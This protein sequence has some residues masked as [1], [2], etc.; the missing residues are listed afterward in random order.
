MQCRLPSTRKNGARPLRFVL[1]K[2]MNTDLPGQQIHVIACGVLAA[3]ISHLTKHL[4]IPCSMEFLPG[5][6]HAR[7]KE[8]RNQLQQRI[9][10]ASAEFRGE[11]IV[12]GY[13]VCGLGTVGLHA[14]NVPLAI[15][16]VNDC[17]ALFLGSNAAYREQFGRYPG[18]YYVSAGWVDENAHPQTSSEHPIQC[19]P[20]CFT[21]QQL[22][23][24]YGEDN[25][26][27]IRDFLNSWQRNYQRAAYI[28]TGVTNRRGYAELARAMAE[29][30]GWKYE[31]LAGTHNLLTELITARHSTERVLCV[32]PHHVTAHDPVNHFLQAV[33]IWKTESATS[34]RDSTL[35]FEPP[36]GHE[37]RHGPQVKRGLGI[38]AG[39]TYTD[40]VLYDFQTD[41]VMAK[42]KSLTTKWDFTRGIGKALD[43]LG[44][45]RPQDVELVSISTTLATNAIVENRGQKVGLLIFPP[46]GLFKPSHIAFRPIG[47]LRGELEID[48][49]EREPVD[50]DVVRTE[51]QRMLEEEKVGAFAVSGYASHVNPAHEQQVKEFLEAETGLSVTCAHEISQQG[52]YRIRAVTAALNASIIPI[53]EAFLRD[54]DRVL[55]QHQIT[56][57]R[58]VVRSDGTLMSLAVARRR[59]IETILS[60][61][62][63]SV[64]GASYLANQEN[65]MVVDMGGTTTDTATIRDGTVRICEKGA[66]VGGWATHVGALELRTLGLGG[67][68]LIA[69]NSNGKPSIGPRRVAP[70]A[71][72]LNNSRGSDSALDWLEANVDR[73]RNSTEGMTLL[74]APEDNEI[75]DLTSGE[76]RVLDALAG[77][78]RCMEELAIR[79]DARHWKFLPLDSLEQQN[80]I[81]KSAL[82][83][84]DLLHATGRL[85]LWNVDTARRFAEIYCR[86]V[87][88]SVDEF[89]EFVHQSIVRRLATELLRKHLAE[90][91]S[92]RDF[93]HSETAAALVENWL[94]E[95][96]DDYRVRVCL[97]HPVVGIGAPVHIYLP[98]AARLLETEAV[99]PHHADVANAI[100]AITSRVVIE[101]TVEIS[102]SDTGGYVLSGLPGAPETNDFRE[103][104]EQAIAALQKIVR[105]QAEQA[106]TSDTRVEI[107]V[108][109]RVAPSALGSQIFIGRV[110]TARL[111]GRP[112]IARLT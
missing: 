51:A 1:R 103:A 11:R 29:Q 20:E 62:A 46:Y 105:H 76:R 63:A 65:A 72:A 81:L 52:N 89:A 100:G 23:R 19:G 99:I 88:Q 24:K 17:I 104:H 74:L 92:D 15:P 54:V 82:T 96:G 58:M 10:Q 68:S 30:F 56:A 71:W 18:T 67:D 33:P 9:D 31:E 26:E 93:D 107:H 80:L 16:R 37:S 87:N 57:P 98:D 111:S 69:C 45:P 7:P 12:V 109:D 61:P 36:A 8:L 59:P 3:D 79:L 112:D 40:V 53:L 28:D 34:S 86:L 106:G 38:D 60:G 35:V 21:L 25:A 44:R 32:P 91:D 78:A 64:A 42:A 95:G 94:Q 13:G 49:R 48:G 14:R 22:V 108:H 85:D 6:L 41:E 97:N 83:P 5:G 55:Q 50:L 84:T 90:N 77:G 73:F 47:I 75:A 27:A 102:P 4:G 66:S 43:A 2:L 101:K 110:L 70:V 39:G